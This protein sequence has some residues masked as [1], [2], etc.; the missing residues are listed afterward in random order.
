MSHADPWEWLKILDR[1]EAME[2]ETIVPGHG[3]VCTIETLREVRVY[4]NE[5][6]ELA[7]TLGPD[8]E[9]FD[10]VAIPEKYDS[11]LF[12]MD[13]KG[14]LKKIRELTSGGPK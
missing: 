3:E 8:D 12:R 2:I 5:M 14:D 4:L 7:G 6:I 1:I 10:H 11:W 9:S 13:F